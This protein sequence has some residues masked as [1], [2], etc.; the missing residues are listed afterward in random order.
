MAGYFV[1][2]D[3]SIEDV[4]PGSWVVEM[5]IDT[6]DLSAW[7]KALSV[8]AVFLSIGVARIDGI[9][10]DVGV[11]LLGDTHDIPDEVSEVWRKVTTIVIHL[12]HGK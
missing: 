6:V 2:S 12:L 4:N 3:S 5:T 10:H 8:D 1:D 9:H 11:K 7:L